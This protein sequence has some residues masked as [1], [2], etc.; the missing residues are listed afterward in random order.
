MSKTDTE[1]KLEIPIK[2]T[3]PYLGSNM[4]L[5]NSQH[6]PFSLKFPKDTASIVFQEAAKEMSTL[7]RQL[8]AESS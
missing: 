8:R 1:K 7:A 4:A 5:A 2:A 3:V 6:Q